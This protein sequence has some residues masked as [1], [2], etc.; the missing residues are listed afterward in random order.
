MTVFLDLVPVSILATGIK[1][2]SN[3]LYNREMSRTENMRLLHLPQSLN[4]DAQI[5]PFCCWCHVF[6]KHNECFH[7][8]CSHFQY[9]RIRLFFTSPS[10][11]S[12]PHYLAWRWQSNI[13]TLVVKLLCPICRKCKFISRLFFANFHVKNYL[14]I[15]VLHF[16]SV[17]KTVCLWQPSLPH[18]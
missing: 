5:L 16:R 11:P 18:C 2:H 8:P 10:P 12:T 3:N 17:G 1:D 14:Q 9:S 15:S 6:R 13:E 7:N 4:F